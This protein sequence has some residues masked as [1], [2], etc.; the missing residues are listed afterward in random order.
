M[1]VYRAE[2]PLSLSGDPQK[3]IGLLRN[4]IYEKDME[5]RHL[6]SHLDRDNFVEGFF[7]NLGDVT[8]VTNVEEGAALPESLK[9][10]SEYFSGDGRFRGK[11]QSTE[12]INGRDGAA[13]RSVDSGGSGEYFP[14]TSMKSYSG[15]W[16]MGTLDDRLVFVYAS[17]EKYIA[18]MNETKRISIGKDGSFAL[19]GNAEIGG[20]FD[21]SGTSL[22]GG[23][24]TAKKAV[25]I[26][27]DSTG[28]VPFT[29]RRIISS[30]EYAADFGVGNP[31]TGVA[32][33]MMRVLNSSGT[34]LASFNLLDG[35]AS[36]DDGYFYAPGGF[37][38]N[39]NSSIYGKNSG[40][41]WQ[42]L[43]NLTNGDSLA[44]GYGG[45]SAAEGST[46]IYA[47][48]MTL[49]SKNY[50]RVYPFDDTYG[51]IRF[52]VLNSQVT[53]TP[54]KT[55]S[56]YLGYSSYRWSTVYA[57][58][59]T[60]QTSDRNLKEDIR[61]IDQKYEELFMRLRPVT[62]KLKGAEHDR[63]HVGFIAQEVEEAMSEVGL[64]AEE[65][66]ALCIDEK[67][68]YDEETCAEKIVLAENGEP[69]KLYSLRYQEFDGLQT[70]MIQK[71]MKEFESFKKKF[72]E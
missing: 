61:D 72:S 18:G 29:A 32:S 43:M 30:S 44:I 50:V 64:T 21:V 24:V 5:L 16:E 2:S 62:Y 7:E 46:D 37:R 17:D 54:D 53:I 3:D 26:D 66:A 70:R 55:G 67:T 71:L 60:I 69:V 38:M 41:T 34:A 23:E 9:L 6:L 4:Y 68:E 11:S 57:T 42:N 19:P 56:G 1:S 35:Y 14:L 12:Y 45:Y 58:N 31:S 27:P 33:A 13:F 36:L 40:G 63:I 22:L 8:N 25:I 49:R 10:I 48:T 39:N 59:G 47:N 52:H 51:H 20:N 15:S 28:Y 65:F